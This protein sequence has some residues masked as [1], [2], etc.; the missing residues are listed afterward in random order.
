MQLKI[1]SRAVPSAV[2][3]GK[4]PAGDDIMD[5]RMIGHLTAP[6]VQQLNPVLKFNDKGIMDWQ[7][8]I[9]S[10]TLAL[11]PINAVGFSVFYV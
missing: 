7:A 3:F 6:G 11:V 5:V 1:D 4:C 9:T 10:N 8:R 2:G